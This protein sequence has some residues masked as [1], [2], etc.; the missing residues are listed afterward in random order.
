MHVTLTLQF[1][2]FPKLLGQT[3]FHLPEA[4]I[5]ELGGIYM[6]CGQPGMEV[7]GQADGLQRAA[8]RMVRRIDGQ[9]QG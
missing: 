2:L 9:Q 8:V 3:P 5:V 6:C 7:R 4:G 1:L